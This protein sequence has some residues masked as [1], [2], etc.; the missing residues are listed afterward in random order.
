MKVMKYQLRKHT[1]SNGELNLGHFI[2]AGGVAGI[3][4]WL[5]AIPFDVSL[6]HRPLPNCVRS[7]EQSHREHT[8]HT[9]DLTILQ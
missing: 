7:T 2:I 9:K 8:S 5:P 6:A 1:T 4:N 3:F